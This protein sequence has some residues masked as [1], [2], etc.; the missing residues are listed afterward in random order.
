M[1]LG[2]GRVS[3]LLHVSSS[4]TRLLL[5]MTEGKWVLLVPFTIL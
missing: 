2:V 5:P 1:K 4:E 3:S